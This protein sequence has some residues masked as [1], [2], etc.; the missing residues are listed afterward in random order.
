MSRY[1]PLDK[2]VGA[3]DPTKEKLN[4]KLFTPVVFAP[5]IPLTRV[6]L[7]RQGASQRTVSR[8]TLGLVGLAFVHGAYLIST[9]V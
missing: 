7:T 8:A 3:V 9:L 6:L 5:A 2:R 4:W 1:E